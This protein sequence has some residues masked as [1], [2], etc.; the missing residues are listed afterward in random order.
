MSD[1]SD[2]TSPR[3]NPTATNADL[4]SKV[5]NTAG[6]GAG[7]AVGQSEITADWF[8]G[9]AGNGSLLDIGSSAQL[10]GMSSEALANEVLR[11]IVK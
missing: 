4:P 11:H 1:M 2:I 6:V 8:S 10:R 9:S 7:N 5:A 3:F